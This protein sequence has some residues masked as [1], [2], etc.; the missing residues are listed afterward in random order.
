MD[1]ETTAIRETTVIEPTVT[2]SKIN[3]DVLRMI[4]KPSV[5]WLTLF[6]FDLAVLAFRFSECVCDDFF[7]SH[8]VRGECESC[9]PKLP[10]PG[11]PSKSGQMIEIQ[12]S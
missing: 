10:V 7:R 11:G 4:D 9:E 6:V 3:E 8:F 2:Y 1:H 12:R 5:K